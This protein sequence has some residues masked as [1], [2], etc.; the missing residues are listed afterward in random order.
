MA[1]SYQFKEELVLAIKP[2]VD[3]P[4][5]QKAKAKLQKAIEDMNMKARIAPSSVAGLNKPFRVELGRGTTSAQIQK[6]NAALKDYGYTVGGIGKTSKE[7]WSQASK[8][9]QGAKQSLDGVNDSM[10][11]FS[12]NTKKSFSG[13]SSCLPSRISLNDRIVSD[14]GTY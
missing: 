3:E 12:H 4:E 8:G 11:A 9:A 6:L 14:R 10:G 13:L 7:A 2:T 5:L 1:S